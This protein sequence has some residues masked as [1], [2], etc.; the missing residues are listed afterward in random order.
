MNRKHH[1]FIGILFVILFLFTFSSLS[2]D[3]DVIF[4][5][6]LEIKGNNVTRESYIRGF[7]TL[8]EGTTYDLDTVIDEINKSIT[9]L[10]HT[11]L[12]TNIFFNDELDDDNNLILTVQLR[13]KNYLLFGPDGYSIYEDKSFYFSNSLYLSYTNMFGLSDHITFNLPV[14]ENTGLSVKYSGTKSKIIYDTD[15]KYLYSLKN[16][17][18]WFSI[19]PGVGYR[20]RDNLNSGIRLTLNYNDIYT[21][22]FSPYFE[23]GAR[24][25][26][27]SKIK[28]WYF[29][30]IAP[31]LGYNFN[32]T[33]SYG[34]DSGFSLYRDLF[35]QIVYSVHLG[36]NL[37]WGKVPENFILR[38][39]VR[40]TH[41][42]LYSGDKRISLSNDLNIP[43]PWNN[44]LVIVPFL[45][46]NLIGRDS[47]QFLIGGGLGFH[48]YTRFQDPLIVEIAF[49]K[50]IMLNFQNKF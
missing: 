44:D 26:H 46:T 22:F 17:T 23:L 2:A 24:D 14:Y 37:Q 5:K 29:T 41:Y 27:T 32:G 4:L 11:E 33:T 1:F 21:A 49:G 19:T 30:S 15:L 13:E 18:S 9:N 48:W 40:G 34:I 42:E 47:L 6:Q 39:S 8:Q 25:K 35:F 12:F 20:F 43:L 10:E 7:I 45:D 28:T 36:V 3:D 50:G 38:S 16:R 31:C